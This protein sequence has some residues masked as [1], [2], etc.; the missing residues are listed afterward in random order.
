VADSP[1][2]DDPLGTV[3]DRIDRAQEHLEAIKRELL[4]YY[5]SDPCSLT[6]QFDADQQTDA[7]RGGWS[8]PIQPRLNTLI[9]EFL[10]DTR[11]ALNHLA[12]QLVLQ[13]GGTPTDDS[14][15][16]VWMRAPVAK[17]DGKQAMPNVAGGVSIAARTI[18]HEAQ[19]YQWEG[20]YSS[21]PIW[22]LDKLWN[23]DKH[24][25][26]VARGLNL[27]SRFPGDAPG[28][29]YTAR[30]KSANE[31]EATFALVPDNPEVD[32]DAE[33]TLLVSVVEPEV[34]IELQLVGALEQILKTVV[35]V[36]AAAKDR[37]F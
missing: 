31:Y 24:R 8:A 9:G 29:S 2:R 7:V 33:L 13:N 15:F 25:D 28:F 27:H 5:H 1:V 20:N 19:P 12:R 34:G 35:G 4:V 10:H 11:S 23:I 30:F 32:V 18:I 21:H 16:P 14:G 6:G 37:C 26:V 3:L 17:K 36:V 22:V